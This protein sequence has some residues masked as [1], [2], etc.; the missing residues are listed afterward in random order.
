MTLLLAIATLGSR[1][2]LLLQGPP[3][4]KPHIHSPVFGRNARKTAKKTRI[5][6]SCRPTEI[7]GNKGLQETHSSQRKNKEIPPKKK[8]Q[9]KGRVKSAPFWHIGGVTLLP[10]LKDSPSLNIPADP[11]PSPSRAS[12][13][14]RVSVILVTICPPPAITE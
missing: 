10:S 5:F 13:G 2:S 11:R 4:R 7:L 8:R 1:T 12:K 9:G 14:G 6:Y 3:F